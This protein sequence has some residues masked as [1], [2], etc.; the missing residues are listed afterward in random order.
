MLCNKEAQNTVAYLNKQVTWGSSPSVCRLGWFGPSV[1]ARL[2]SGLCVYILE[3]KLQGQHFPR[4]VLMA[5]HRRDN[6]Q[7]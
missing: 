3:S 5:K 4:E 6:E 7:I 1:Q 2:K